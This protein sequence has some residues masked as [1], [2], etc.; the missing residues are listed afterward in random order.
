M[1]TDKKPQTCI[2]LI[3]IWM[4]KRDIL[5]CNT[6]TQ[7]NNASFKIQLVLNKSDILN[8]KISHMWFP[9]IFW[10]FIVLNCINHQLKRWRVRLPHAFQH[11]LSAQHTQ[12]DLGSTL[13]CRFQNTAQVLTY[14]KFELKQVLL[15][16]AIWLLYVTSSTSVSISQLI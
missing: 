13:Y 3:D 9:A 14:V 2:P 1:H 12:T 6:Q 5:Q 16:A 11:V 8:R 10:P 7:G 4:E 15:P